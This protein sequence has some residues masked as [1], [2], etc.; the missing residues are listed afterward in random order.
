MFALPLS[1]AASALCSF[2]GRET[3]RLFSRQGAIHHWG[4]ECVAISTLDIREIVAQADTMKQAPNS[5]TD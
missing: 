3:L 1:Q 2:D 4:D 5:S